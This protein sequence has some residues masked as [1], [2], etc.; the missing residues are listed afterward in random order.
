MTQR[1]CFGILAEVFPEGDGGLREVPPACFDC[2]DRVLCLKAALKTKEGLEMRAGM[3]ERAEGSGLVGRLRR[4]SQK[5]EV[6]RLLKQEK[7][8]KR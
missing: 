7:A 4:W 1:T 8:K 3:L 6:S 5:K 2:P